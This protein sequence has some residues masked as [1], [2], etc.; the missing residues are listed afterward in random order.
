M[1]VQED[2]EFARAHY[3]RLELTKERKFRYSSIWK[4][5]CPPTNRDLVSKVD[6]FCKRLEK[7]D[8]LREMRLRVKETENFKEF[9]DSDRDLDGEIVEDNAESD[10]DLC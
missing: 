8:L 7:F 2:P 4:C 10:E 5:T 9:C 3:K 6:A 1:R